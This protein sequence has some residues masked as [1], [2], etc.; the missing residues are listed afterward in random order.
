MAVHSFTNDISYGAK[1]N[2]FKIRHFVAKLLIVFANI[3][4]NWNISVVQMYM[5]ISKLGGDPCKHND[6]AWL[7]GLL[8]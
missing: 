4:R 2:K 8:F 6:I 7:V 1:L 3:R 5:H